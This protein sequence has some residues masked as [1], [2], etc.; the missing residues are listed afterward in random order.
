MKDAL[1]PIDKAGRI[2]LPKDIR[3]ELAIK[4]G[5]VFKVS[6]DGPAVT[7]TPEKATAGFVKCGKALVFSAVPAKT[8]TQEAVAT[9]LEGGRD[10]TRSRVEGGLA[11]RKRRQ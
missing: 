3:E 5:D 10:E 11:G 8:L 2:V 1:A 4:P 6:V 9:V 7:L